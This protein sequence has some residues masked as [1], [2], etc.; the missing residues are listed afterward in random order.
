MSTTVTDA[1]AGRTS[2]PIPHSVTHG[3]ITV[4]HLAGAPAPVFVAKTGGEHAQILD[5]SEADGRDLLRALAEALDVPL[6][7]PEEPTMTVRL[8]DR[9]TQVGYEYPRIITVTISAEC[10]TCRGPRGVPYPH[11]FAEDGGWLTCDRWVNPCGH[12]DYY[13]AVLVEAGLRKPAGGAL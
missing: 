5:L 7:L 12:V 1:P 4:S 9:G 6:T 13:G 8:V 11:R 10:P 2:R 3:R